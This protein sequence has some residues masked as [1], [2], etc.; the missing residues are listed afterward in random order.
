V[1]RAPDDL[2][3]EVSFLKK[4]LKTTFD[5]DLTL[6]QLNEH[7]NKIVS[8]KVNDYIYQ[9]YRDWDAFELLK[10][11]IE[12]KTEVE[13]PVEKK[14]EKPVEKAPEKLITSLKSDSLENKPDDKSRKKLK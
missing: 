9:R 13:K 12:F 14:M 4:H 2:S 3:S 10:L 11:L 5:R 7:L 1:K 6:D 8:E